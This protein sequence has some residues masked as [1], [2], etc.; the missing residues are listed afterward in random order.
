MNKTIQAFNELFTAARKRFEYFLEGAII[1]FTEDVVARMGELQIS[2]ADLAKKLNCN[3]AY[4][5][6]VLRG[7]T[8]FTLASM[9]KIGLALDSEVEVRLRVKTVKEDW[10]GI[11]QSMQ[12][13]QRINSNPLLNWPNNRTRLINFEQK[14]RTYIAHE[15]KTTIGILSSATREPG[16]Y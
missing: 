6:K 14:N 2:K 13:Q 3:P 11:L 7:S 5:T 8:N 4:I 1:G 12:R 15:H 10:S 16:I 9:V